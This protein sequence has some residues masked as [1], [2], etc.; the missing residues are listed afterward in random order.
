MAGVLFFLQ[1]IEKTIIFAE[2]KKQYE[3]V[4]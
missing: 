1:K 2:L 4:L 3:Y